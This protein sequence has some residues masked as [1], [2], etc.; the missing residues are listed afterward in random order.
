MTIPGS[1]GEICFTETNPNEGHRRP[2]PRVV[3]IAAEGL[4]RSM[5][6]GRTNWTNGMDEF[7]ASLSQ[8]NRIFTWTVFRVK[9]ETLVG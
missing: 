6:A 1:P 4:T 5:S 2:A 3:I 8:V 7:E 9:S